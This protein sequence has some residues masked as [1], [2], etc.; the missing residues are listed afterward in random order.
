MSTKPENIDINIDYEIDYETANFV[1]WHK[2][3]FS[4]ENLSNDAIPSNNKKTIPRNKTQANKVEIK[5]DKKNCNDKPS[6]V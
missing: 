6:S 2:K 3:H 4:K 5:S 1:K